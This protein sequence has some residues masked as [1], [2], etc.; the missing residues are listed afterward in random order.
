MVQ[1]H[2][3]FGSRSLKKRKFLT[4]DVL[5]FYIQKTDFEGR[6]FFSRL[7]PDRESEK[8]GRFVHGVGPPSRK[9]H[10]SSSSTA[11]VNNKDFLFDVEK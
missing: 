6:N 2:F 7:D 10:S 4:V 1:I 8:S 5:L 3:V 9:H 11:K